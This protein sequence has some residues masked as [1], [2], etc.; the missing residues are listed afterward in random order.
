MK[1]TSSHQDSVVNSVLNLSVLLDSMQTDP[2]VGIKVGHLAGD[3]SFSFFGAEIPAGK[4]VR[5]HYHHKGIEIYYI[6]D[7]SGSMRIGRPNANARIEWTERF[8]VKG[9]DCFTIPEGIA[10]W[11]ENTGAGRLVA[12]FGCRKPHLSTDRVIVRE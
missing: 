4:S 11:L 1:T 12:L 5:A 3:D 8:D 10:H 2:A 6:V 7:G 9:G